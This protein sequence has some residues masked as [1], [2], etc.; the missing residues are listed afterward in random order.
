MADDKMKNDDLNPGGSKQAGQQGG[1][2]A[3]SRASNHRE[4]IQMKSKAVRRAARAR[5]VASKMMS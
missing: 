5:I 3:N 2:V 1:Q 4:E